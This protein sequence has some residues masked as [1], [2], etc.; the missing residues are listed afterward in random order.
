MCH[1]I[2]KQWATSGDSSRSVKTFTHV[3]IAVR[4]AA[5]Y[6]VGW[7]DNLPQTWDFPIED[8]REAA[9]VLHLAGYEID[10]SAV[11]YGDVYGY[12]WHELYRTWFAPVR[13]TS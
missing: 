7:V 5:M 12:M 4:G 1:T 3:E 6:L 10:M 13:R 8:R 11:P 2:V 9:D